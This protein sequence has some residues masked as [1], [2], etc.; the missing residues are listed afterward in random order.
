MRE[1]ISHNRIAN[2]ILIKRNKI[3]KIILVE[4]SND[5]LF[6]SKFK[7]SD[8]FLELAFGWENVIMTINE[9]LNQN[10]QACIGIIDSDLKPIIPED[11]I[12]PSNVFCTDCHDINIETIEYSFNV[13]YNHHCSSEKSLSFKSQKNIEDIKSYTYELSKPLSFLRILSKRNKYNLCFK[14]KND[15]SNSLDYSKFINKDKYEFISLE[16][17]VETVIN[18]SINR[19]TNK[20]P[21][22]K[23]IIDE[24]INL[25]KTEGNDYEFKHL[26]NGHD[27]GEI[28]ALGLKKS[29]GSNQHIKADIFLKECILNYEYAEF[30]KTNL[31]NNIVIFEDKNNIKYL[32]N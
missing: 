7:E 27:F 20:I 12:I 22:K 23:I 10:F 28:M 3:K 6:F 25:L 16:K 21:D 19:T 30:K 18:F 4:G 29:L 1:S 2:A 15:D 14:S 5:M 31:Y 26:T 17:L 32:K 13:I 24:L 11:I 8:C 9:L